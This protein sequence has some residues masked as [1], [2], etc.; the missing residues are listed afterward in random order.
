[1]TF[2]FVFQEIEVVGKKLINQRI[3]DYLYKY[4]DLTI[5]YGYWLN[6][7]APDDKFRIFCYNLVNNKFFIL[8]IDILI[9][10]N[11]IKFGLYNYKTL[12]QDDKEHKKRVFGYVFCYSGSIFFD[13]ICMVF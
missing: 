6:Y 5:M 13:F 1:M 10:L 11:V 12:S 3:W 7:F 2:L 4:R 8:F 9:I